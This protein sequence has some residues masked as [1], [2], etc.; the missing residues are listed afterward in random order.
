[1]ERWAKT[2]GACAL[3]AGLAA[4]GGSDDTAD[5]APQMHLTVTATE[6][7][8]GSWGSVGAY[9]KITGT[10]SGEVDPKDRHNA[11]IQD[12]SLAPRN[13]RGKEIG[14]AHV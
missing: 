11:I 9:E 4:C 10:L 3:A 14:R 8:P 5:A 1:M 12:L 13:S 2:W 7:F 6:D